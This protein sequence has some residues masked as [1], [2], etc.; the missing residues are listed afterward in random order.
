MKLLI[1][2]GVIFIACHA[3][4]KAFAQ[5]LA[6]DKCRHFEFLIEHAIS[7]REQGIPLDAAQKSLADPFLEPDDFTDY[8][9]LSISIRSAYQN[10]RWMRQAISTGYW[11]QL[12]VQILIGQ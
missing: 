5:S 7:M 4:Y 11:R 9:V 6:Q 8:Q 3:T 1:A 10:P 2:F 12:C